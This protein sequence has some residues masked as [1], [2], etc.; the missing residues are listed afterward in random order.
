MKQLATAVALGC[1]LISPFSLAADGDTQPVQPTQ[2]ANASVADIYLDYTAKVNESTN[3]PIDTNG[4]EAYITVKV[5]DDCWVTGNVEVSW[6][7]TVVNGGDLVKTG[8]GVVFHVSG[9]GTLTIK[10][11]NSEESDNSWYDEST[12]YGEVL[13]N[14]L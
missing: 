6:N 4:R 3:I 1:A 5:D 14:I 13:I 2:V 9:S 8:A 12:L 11:L 10:N 7:G